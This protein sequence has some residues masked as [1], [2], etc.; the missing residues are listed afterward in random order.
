MGDS[1]AARGVHRLEQRCTLVSDGMFG[2]GARLDV[3][4]VHRVAEVG[5]MI[6][7]VGLGFMAVAGI[8]ILILWEAFAIHD[9]IDDLSEKR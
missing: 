6:W 8:G 3:L 5:Q 4:G 7:I 2:A 9:S 1:Y